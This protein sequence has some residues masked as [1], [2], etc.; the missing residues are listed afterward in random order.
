MFVLIPFV[1][2]FGVC[3]RP[4]ADSSGQPDKET[5]RHGYADKDEGD[6]YAE[7]DDNWPVQ[8][9]HVDHHQNIGSASSPAIRVER[10]AEECRRCN[11]FQIDRPWRPRQDSSTELAEAQHQIW[12]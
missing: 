6:E 9:K 3:H 7:D 1:R 12:R 10:R 8:G 5:S 2:S 11:F 4:V